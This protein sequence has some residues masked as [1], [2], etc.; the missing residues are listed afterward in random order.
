MLHVYSTVLYTVH[1]TD[2]RGTETER[3][4]LESCQCSADRRAER[5]E[6]GCHHVLPTL[7][8]DSE[9]CK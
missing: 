3:E 7:C 9:G 5:R 6:R 8:P 2:Y 1:C 4:R